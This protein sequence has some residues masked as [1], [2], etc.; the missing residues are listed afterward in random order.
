MR[1]QEKAKEKWKNVNEFLGFSRW[2][3]VDCAYVS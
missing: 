3:V 1:Q 2:G